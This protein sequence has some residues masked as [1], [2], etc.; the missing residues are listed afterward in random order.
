MRTFVD[1]S[2]FLG[3]IDADEMRH[4]DVRRAWV[5]LLERKAPLLTTNYVLV[6]TH[7]LIQRRLGLDALRC[8]LDDMLPVVRVHWVD[9]TEHLA[10]A[11][12]LLAAG[13]RRLSL[14]DCV[15][16][17]VMRVRGIRR[18]LTLDRHFSEQGFLCLPG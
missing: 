12:A 11:T 5:D 13:K 7:A 8:W 6:E 3:L 15:S 1:T 4:A 10:A 16:F 14:V 2:A 9:E 18:A 17:E